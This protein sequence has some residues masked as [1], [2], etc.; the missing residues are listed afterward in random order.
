[1]QVLR[2]LVEEK[3]RAKAVREQ[4]FL[5]ARAASAKKAGNHRGTGVAVGKAESIGNGVTDSTGDRLSHFAG[6]WF[7]LRAR[8][9]EMEDFER[10]MAIPTCV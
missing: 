10:G 3:E 1:M 5:A 7:L 9:A 8:E 6:V 2:C 4:S